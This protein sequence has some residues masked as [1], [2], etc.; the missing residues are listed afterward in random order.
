[1]NI[2]KKTEG[3]TVTLCLNGWMDTNSAPEFAEALNGIDTDAEA[4]VLDLAKL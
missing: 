3:K 2:E 1:M 4:L